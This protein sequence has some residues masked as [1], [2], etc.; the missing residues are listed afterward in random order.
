MKTGNKFRFF[1]V[2]NER[3]RY[4]SLNLWLLTQFKDNRK[5]FFLSDKNVSLQAKMKGYLMAASLGIR[6]PISVKKKKIKIFQTNNQ[7]SRRRLAMKINL[8]NHRQ[9]K[10]KAQK[11]SKEEIEKTR[12]GCASSQYYFWLQYSHW[13][14]LVFKDKRKVSWLFSLSDLEHKMTKM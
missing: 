4:T 3:S 14:I 8:F 9:S 1:Y 7:I 2:L 10:P 11:I 13:E 12:L 6:Y 5:L